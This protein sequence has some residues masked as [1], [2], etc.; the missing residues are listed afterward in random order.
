MQ[1]RLGGGPATVCGLVIDIGSGSVGAAL[2]ASV[3]DTE[4]PEVIWETRIQT[5]LRAKIGLI[6]ATQDIRTALKE[7]VTAAVS[8]GL[9]AL[10]ATHKRA[11]VTHVEVSLSAPWALTITKAVEVTHETPFKF[12]KE[13]LN[14]MNDTARKQAV[15]EFEKSKQASLHD[16]EL[17]SDVE[18]SVQMN[19][20]HVLDP[21][22]KTATTVQVS[23]LIDLGYQELVA[24][25]DA[26][27]ERAF[28]AALHTATSFMHRYFD[29]I[30][31]LTVDT[32]ELCLIDVSNEATEIGVVRNGTLTHV[33]YT[34][35]GLRSIIREIADVC[36]IPLTEA[37]HYLRDSPTTIPDRCTDEVADVISLYETNL[38]EL[39]GRTGDKLSIPSTLFVYTDPNTEAFISE[40]VMNAARSVT[41]ARHAVHPVTT[42]FFDAVPFDDVPLLLVMY[43]FHRKHGA[44]QRK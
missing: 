7:A 34:P 26:E 33:T 24:A 35:Y 32:T 16:L 31:S 19:G 5:P 41:N 29:V 30:R 2:V 3:Q 28:P 11:R 37:Q 13:M 12:T 40:R 18:M 42:R 17:I 15:Q 38:A 10:A 6:D 8:S 4:V 39:F 22:G 21:I 36:D 1:M 43:A 20:Y 27:L 14:S 23:R 44:A 25:V 9:P